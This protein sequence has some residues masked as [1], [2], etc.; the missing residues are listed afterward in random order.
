MS[1][2]SYMD[3]LSD[4]SPSS[5]EAIPPWRS[6]QILS[7]GGTSSNFVS[8]SLNIL[9]FFENLMQK[10]KETLDS[11][12]YGGVGLSRSP[13]PKLSSY[14]AQRSSVPQ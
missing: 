3:F 5:S 7:F 2:Q 10:Q 9:L 6:H 8:M 1:D 12:A 4:S 11:S 14:L 13:L